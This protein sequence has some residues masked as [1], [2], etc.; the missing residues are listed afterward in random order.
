MNNMNVA[1]FKTKEQTRLDKLISEVKQMQPY[2]QV[3]WDDE[4]WNLEGFVKTRNHEKRSLT[5]LFTRSQ[6]NQTGASD[7]FTQ[8]FADFA[9]TII[10]HRAAARNTGYTFQK[11]MVS[12]LRYLYEALF[13]SGSVDPAP[14]LK[15]HF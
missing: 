2:P 7:P 8:P 4:R 3:V 10:A 9:K 15:L 11:A 13:P 5:I 14:L 12:A 1:S 6:K